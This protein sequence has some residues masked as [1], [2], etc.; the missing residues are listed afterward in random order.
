MKE[1]LHN[2]LEH[3]TSK[4]VGS[5]ES[6]EHSVI[7]EEGSSSSDNHHHMHKNSSSSGVSSDLSD[8]SDNESSGG[9]GGGGG[10]RGS[11]NNAS[12]MEESGIFVEAEKSKSSENKQLGEATIGTQTT[13]GEKN[14]NV[15]EVDFNSC[16]DLREACGGLV[17]RKN[18][19]EKEIEGYKQ[20]IRTLKSAS[21]AGRISELE[22]VEFSLRNQLREWEDKFISLKRQN[23]SAMEDRYKVVE[24][25]ILE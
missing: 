4:S 8:S 3:H 9:S 15:G 21:D 7:S 10:G 22:R 5:L 1:H 24:A 2:A 11:R 6:H 18:D 16:N 12:T 25:R 20:E 14:D 17:T 23:L 13:S 19:L